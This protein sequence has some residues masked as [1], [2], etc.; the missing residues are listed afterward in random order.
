MTTNDTEDTKSNAVNVAHLDDSP[1]L[2][3]LTGF[4]RDVL[5]VIV[6]LSQQQLNGVTIKQELT[7]HYDE[8]IN[9]ARLYQNLRDL[10]DKG[11]VKTRPIDGRTKAY[12]VSQ[13]GHDWLDTYQE[14]IAVC[15]RTGD[16]ASPSR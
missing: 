3:R 1:S 2:E 15:L 6:N 8:E 10:I 14:W 16:D 12:Q 5:A 13:A 9:Q 7:V 4:Q 11:Y